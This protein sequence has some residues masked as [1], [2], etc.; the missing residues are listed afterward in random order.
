MPLGTLHQAHYPNGPVRLHRQP[1]IALSVSQVS[2]EPLGAVFQ[3]PGTDYP[4]RTGRDSQTHRPVGRRL[5][6][7]VPCPDEDLRSAVGRVD[8][9]Q[10]ARLHRLARRVEPRHV[11]AQI[12]LRHHV[13]DGGDKAVLRASVRH[14]IQFQVALQGETP[15]PLAAAQT[16]RQPLLRIAV[17]QIFRTQFRG[18]VPC[19]LQC[20]RT[21]VRTG[22]VH[23]VDPDVPGPGAVGDAQE[24]VARRMGTGGKEHHVARLGHRR[25]QV[26]QRPGH[27]VQQRHHLHRRIGKHQQLPITFVFTE[28][29]GQARCAAFQL[30]GRHRARRAGGH[31]Q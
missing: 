11:M 30:P 27:T 9:P 15:V 18:P 24:P 26:R 25:G 31:Y 8:Q 16:C 23:G 22:V 21:E 12:A 13:I 10:P 19:Q 14:H 5:P 2:G 7:V 3:V 29:T 20:D 1:P 4:G 6:L 28:L 17:L